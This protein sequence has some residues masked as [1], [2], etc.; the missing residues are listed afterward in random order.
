MLAVGEGL[1][2]E[3]WFSSRVRN[4]D[5]V[6]VMISPEHDRFMDQ[7]LETLGRWVERGRRGEIGTRSFGAGKVFPVGGSVAWDGR[8]LSSRDPS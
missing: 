4:P 7:Y 3:G 5:G 1:Y 8:R 2:R 6:Q